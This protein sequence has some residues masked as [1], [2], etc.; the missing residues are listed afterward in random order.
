[1]ADEFAEEDEDSTR[2]ERRA[3]SRKEDDSIVRLVGIHGTKRWAIIAQELNADIPGV[4]RSGKQCRTRWLNHL[5]PNIKKDPWSE[6]EERV[7]YEAQ[8]RL[9]N[10]WAEIAKVLPGRT[11]NAIKNHW[12]STMRRNMR[13]L[14]KEIDP[15]EEEGNTKK[16]PT[17]TSS[18]SSSSN[19]AAGF[20]QP[21]WPR[22]TTSTSNP[23]QLGH[24]MLSGMLPS[25]AEHL[26]RA[27]GQ[28]K[29]M[30]ANKGQRSPSAT[31][32]GPLMAAMSATNL[33][34][35]NDSPFTRKF[36]SGSAADIAALSNALGAIPGLANLGLS[37][38]NIP[39]IINPNSEEATTSSFGVSA[40][41]GTLLKLFAHSP[42]V[43]HQS[44]LSSVDQLRV[45]RGPA[46]ASES[47]EYAAA[48]RGRKVVLR[49]PLKNAGSEV[50][51]DAPTKRL[52][53]DS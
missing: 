44:A 18:G 53:T 19:L 33:A 45:L 13:R 7:I 52:K 4:F 41:Y 20:G 37:S 36:K 10:K 48:R 5:D 22:E 43:S 49:N 23:S 14:A 35:Q 39:D 31:S 21:M 46:L 26:N 17:S 1:M 6:E 42:P 11:D 47:L 38:V 27:Y 50:L 30:L 25:N 32:S 9:G 34:L 15:D 12:Y 51:R 3:W 8:Q 28:I 16:L 2:P 40:Q 24:A 29:D